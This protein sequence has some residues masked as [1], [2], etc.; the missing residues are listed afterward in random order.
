M[1]RE[2]IVI[3]SGDG[4]DPGADLAT[5]ETVSIP[6]LWL[7]PARLRRL[8][9]APIAYID[10]EVEN[11]R[12]HP[13]RR[14]AL[15]Q[16]FDT[17]GRKLESGDVLLFYVTDHGQINKDDLR[18]NTITLWKEDLSVA[19]LREM[20]VAIPPDVS[21]VMLM[22][23]CFSGSFANLALPPDNVC[24][25]FASTADRPAYGCYPE[26]R[27]VDGVGHS[28]HFFE[29]LDALGQFPQAHDRILVTDD[30]PDV[31]N[32]SSEFFLAETISRA[33]GEGDPGKLTDTL[34]NRAWEDRARW[35]PEI[36]LIDRISN[37]F[38]IFSPRSLAELEQQTR[39]LPE[40]S[41]R[42]GTYAELWGNALDSLLLANLR[43]F[44]EANPGWEERLGP[45]ELKE[46]APEARA[47]MATELLSLLAPFT[48]ADSE[49]YERMLLLR[50][51]ADIA[52]AAAY[53]M[54][55]R[56]GV[57]LRLRALLTDIAGR[58][59][60]EDEGSDEE[61]ESYHT[62]R[63]CE[64]LALLTDTHF[65]SAAELDSPAA[66]PRL[67]A[68]QEL[69]DTI[70]PAWMG[71][72]FRPPTEEQ[73]EETGYAAGAV[74]VLTVYPDSAAAAAGLRI[75]DTILGPPDDPFVEPNQVREW[76]MRREIGEP[77][78]L[79]VAREGKIIEVTLR[80][81]PFP[82]EMPKLPGPPKKG[83]AAPDLELEP[84]RGKP[85]VQAG[86]PTL[87]FFWAT[88]CAPCKFA[89]PEVMEYGKQHGTNVIA[90]TDESEKTLRKFFADFS[91]PFP[92]TV[93][94]DPYRET[95]QSYGVS[96]TPTFVLIDADGKVAGYTTGYNA[97][98][99]LNFEG[100]ELAK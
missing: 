61:R 93:A 21:V 46:L 59:Y 23:Q 99:G 29:A 57:V 39:T 12:L 83:T 72:R 100:W 43:D 7:L 19:E 71:I 56:L 13:A 45:K 48:R 34:I 2:N 96:G 87:L 11:Y 10:S 70:M 16:W 81:G 42:L 90:I 74:R 73:M 60:L 98:R 89:L 22:S 78:P 95:F 44:V 76:T 92:P 51:R 77:A 50:E 4:S 26:N 41:E 53:R 3:F 86:K 9:G 91:S 36:R 32:T 37:T 52:A 88:W 47:E 94:I 55:V 27:G 33:A 20:L 17:A 25:Y 28:H 38:G 35:E 66:F 24:G 85:Q 8:A 63:Q 54:E 1:D 40:V 5:R 18:D 67:A 84:F 64:D 58:V 75:G 31:P 6:D 14:D 97:E 49:R 79:S 62:L 80:P 30:S 15:A 82:L 65:D 69:V 68:D